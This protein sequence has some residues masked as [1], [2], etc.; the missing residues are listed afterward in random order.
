M[1]KTER[2]HLKFLLFNNKL[3]IEFTIKGVAKTNRGYCSNKRRKDQ[4]I[5]MGKCAN[6][7]KQDGDACMRKYID[8]LQGTENHNDINVKIPLAC[9]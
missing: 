6:A 4:F 2:I 8:N 1:K 3:I 5:S 7:I 9:W